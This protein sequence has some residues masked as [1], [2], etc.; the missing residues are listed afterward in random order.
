MPRPIALRLLA[1]LSAVLLAGCATTEK[2][3]LQAAPMN[4]SVTGFIDK[5]AEAGGVLH[6]YVAYVPRHY[7]PDQAWPLVIFLHG[8]GER[9]GDGLVQTEVGIGTA[10]RRRPEQWP[11]IV[12]MPQC[13][14]GQLWDAALPAVEAAIARTTEE[15]RIDPRRVYLTGLS[16]GGYGAWLWAGLA[17]ERFAA[18]MPI[19]GG[20]AP[21]KIARLSETGGGADFGTLEQ[22]VRALATVPVWAFHGATDEVVPPEE[23]RDMVRRVRAAG[24]EVH[25]TEFP[26]TGHNSWDQAYAHGEA[27]RW[28]FE[29]R[30][31]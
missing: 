28:L 3:I 1:A 14:E 26:D 25:Y 22:R 8:A 31:P 30:K 24:G 13:P 7:T 20:G 21:E 6:P 19:C 12:I 17:P 15:Y 9:G 23:S 2:P 11:A 5:T 10:L 29:Q 16:M 27:V 4:S 18:V